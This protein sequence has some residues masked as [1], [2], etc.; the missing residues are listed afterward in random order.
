MLKDEMHRFALTMPKKKMR[1]IYTFCPLDR[2]ELEAMF[3]A[4]R[5]RSKTWDGMKLAMFLP[6]EKWEGMIHISLGFSNYFDK[7]IVGR[8]A[9]EFKKI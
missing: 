1:Y 6:G 9:A 7:D 5:A 3:Q 4:K 2:D 8:I